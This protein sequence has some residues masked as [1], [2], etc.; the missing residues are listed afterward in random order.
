MIKFNIDR[1]LLIVVTLVLL[2]GQF[3]KKQDKIEIP[4]VTVNIPETKGSTDKETIKEYIPYPVEIKGESVN[5]DGE[6][7]R[8]YEE[9]S[10]S[11]ER[12]KLYLE[13]IKIN[14]YSKTFIDDS[15]LNLKGSLTTRG[16][17]LDYQFDYT[18]KEKPFTY[19]PK[20]IKQFPKLSMK[21]GSE[22]GLSTRDLQEFVFKGNLGFINQKGDEITIS[23]DTNETFWLGYNKNIKLIK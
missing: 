22:V 6:W 20:V 7:K 8:K 13:A 18:V 9:L 15:I 5:V 23:Y 16:E 19:Q 10:D 14:E 2:W 11:L 17:L 4:P 3:F 21:I 1:I 12:Y